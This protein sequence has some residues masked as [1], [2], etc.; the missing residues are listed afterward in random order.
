MAE[1]FCDAPRLVKDD[2]AALLAL[3]ASSVIALNSMP[4]TLEKSQGV[5][6]P[7]TVDISPLGFPICMLSGKATLG[8]VTDQIGGIPLTHPR[9]WFWRAGFGL[10]FM[11]VCVLAIAVSYLLYRG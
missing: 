5:D 6:K 4:A 1:A 8:S 2:P 9:R 11:A 10:S 7:K 3:A